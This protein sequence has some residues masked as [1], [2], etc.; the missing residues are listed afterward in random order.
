MTELTETG[1]MIQY[2]GGVSNATIATLYI[3]NILR[4]LPNTKEINDKIYHYDVVLANLREVSIQIK[5][6]TENK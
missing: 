3:L 2:F 5:E 1:S 4:N 6:Q